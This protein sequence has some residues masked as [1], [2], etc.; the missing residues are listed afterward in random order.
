M[1]VSILNGEEELVDVLTEPADNILDLKLI[2]RFLFLSGRDGMNVSI[3]KIL[4]V[5]KKW[6]HLPRLALVG[7]RSVSV[8]DLP[9]TKCPS[10]KLVCHLILAMKCLN[11]L[12][13]YDDF[14]D[15]E[16]ITLKR[17]VDDWVKLRRPGFIFE[18]RNTK[19]HSSDDSWCSFESISYTS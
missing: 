7:D 11:C 19:P 8:V 10:L 17:G 6:Q 12:Y 1:E 3:R 4:S 18:I 16:M 13:I 5:F 9:P 14:N 15:N 2:L